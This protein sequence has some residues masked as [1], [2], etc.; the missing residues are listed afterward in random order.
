MK[1]MRKY[2]FM[3]ALVAVV[4]ALSTATSWAQA[5]IDD[6]GR[7]L[8]NRTRI[9][10][11][12]TKQF[13]AGTVNEPGSQLLYLA[14]FGSK[15]L[16]D[17]QRPVNFLSVTNV[18][19]T[20]AVT[21]HVRY[22]SSLNCT[23]VLDFLIVLTPNDVWMFNPFT[24]VIPRPDGTSTGVTASS[25]LLS[26]SAYGD[27]RFLIF[28]SASG[29]FD[30]NSTKSTN[31]PIFPDAAG[32]QVANI[33]FP[34]SVYTANNDDG[35]TAPLTGFNGVDNRLGGQKTSTLD[36]TL[37]VRTVKH[38]SFN[39]L[40]GSQTVA[41]IVT[42]G[43]GTGE[44]RSF[45]V[46]AHARPAVVFDHASTTTLAGTPANTAI[47]ATE[48]ISYDRDGDGPQADFR[49]I[50]TGQEPTPDVGPAG[51]QSLI[52]NDNYLRSEIQNG[53]YVPFLSGLTFTQTAIAGNSSTVSLRIGW[54][55]NG[56][57]LAWDRIFQSDDAEATGASPDKQILNFISFEDDYN[58]SGEFGFPD[59]RGARVV[60]AHTLLVP[61]IFN[62]AEVPLNQITPGCDISPCGPGVT[63]N[64]LAVIC[65]NTFFSDANFGG[66][67]QLGTVG[68]ATLRDLF[69]LTPPSASR[70]VQQ[71]VGTITPDPVQGGTDLSS[72]WIRFNRSVQRLADVTIF[73]S[74]TPS[75]AVS[76]ADNTG[77]SS[78][79][80]TR[81][82]A[83]PTSGAS[84]ATATGQHSYVLLGR[85]NIQFGALGAAYWMHGVSDEP[86][87]NP[88][89]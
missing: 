43:A 83:G 67:L 20:T 33:L 74:E 13:P 31:M 25:Q 40:I 69:G 39:F 23:D 4:V 27:G 15:G 48:V 73:N 61:Q 82:Q 12:G 50:L 84:N 41:S 70:T 10:E 65:I 36:R 26:S 8:A 57:A 54:Q 52:V 88:V 80:Q 72:G 62:N 34:N 59:A 44:R 47:V 18:H 19:P 46:A 37:N 55:V 22:F 5:P 29:A 89:P 66:L 87:S 1:G 86:A 63:T 51:S 17:A 30:P 28:I 9:G 16:T 68:D 24:I 32:R 78:F 2:L 77:A 6:T 35:G 49:V 45:G 56:G 21:V 64:L 14:D 79:T 76:V 71:H 75:R 60:S 58:G 11:D 42:A 38:I 53:Y 7:F 81:N 3:M 85:Y